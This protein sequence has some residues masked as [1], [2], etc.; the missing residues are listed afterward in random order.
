MDRVLDQLPRFVAGLAQMIPQEV[1]TEELEAQRQRDEEETAGSA[2]RDDDRHTDGHLCLCG[3]DTSDTP[4][5]EHMPRLTAPTTCPAVSCGC[6]RGEKASV[7]DAAS[8][9]RDKDNKTSAF[10][11]FFPLMVVVC[12]SSGDFEKACMTKFT[13]S[14][15]CVGPPAPPRETAN[16][17][18]PQY[19]SAIGWIESIV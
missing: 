8:E 5:R 6:P 15:V 4:K 17:K 7:F 11:M 2:H 14:C 3:F 18:S 10:M 13:S 12:S 9:D 16:R 1:A 19:C